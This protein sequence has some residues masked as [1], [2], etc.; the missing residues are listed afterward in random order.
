MMFLVEILASIKPLTTIINIIL[1]LLGKNEKGLKLGLLILV[2]F[3]PAASIGFILNDWIENYL[4]DNL[5][6]IAAA[7]LI[8]AFLMFFTESRRKQLLLN[9][10]NR[11]CS[12]IKKQKSVNK[13]IN[14][15]NYTEALS[16]GFAQCLA[17]WPGMSRSMITIV[18]GYWIGLSPKK[19]AEYSFLLGLITLSAAS[20][21]KLLTDGTLLVKNLPIGPMLL[22]LIVAFISAIYAI[23][24][25]VACL[26]KYGMA[27]FAWYRICLAAI[28]IVFFIIQSK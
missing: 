5:I 4:S 15:L 9:T 14:D 1:G 19:A 2:S 17:L 12:I 6:V 27:P 7:L 28:I 10:E 23:K 13:D 3:I 18:A 16:I 8:G 22:G 26:N 24:F 25:L 11:N 20:A 21:Y